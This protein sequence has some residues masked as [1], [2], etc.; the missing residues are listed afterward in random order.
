M[1]KKRYSVNGTF[2]DECLNVHWFST[3]GDAR[4]K[5]TQWVDEYRESASQ[6]S[7]K[8]VAPGI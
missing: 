4:S 3:L 8:P 1:R 7:R 2:R 5:I 6:G